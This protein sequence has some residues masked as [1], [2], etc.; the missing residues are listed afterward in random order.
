MLN[1]QIPDVQPPQPKPVVRVS[2]LDT[3]EAGSSRQ[4][5]ADAPLRLDERPVIRVTHDTSPEG[6]KPVPGDTMVSLPF[7]DLSQKAKQ[8][9]RICNQL[10]NM[11]SSFKFAVH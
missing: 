10:L 3:H 5:K 7:E 9:I 8:S 11:P 1:G 2:I 6:S 4:H